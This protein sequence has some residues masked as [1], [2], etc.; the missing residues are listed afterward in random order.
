MS[1]ES[2]DGGRG[3]G[4]GCFRRTNNS[5]NGGEEKSVLAAQAHAP[6]LLPHPRPAMGWILYYAFF[7]LKIN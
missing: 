2:A 1:G 4:G 3:G 6:A 7:Q 5:G